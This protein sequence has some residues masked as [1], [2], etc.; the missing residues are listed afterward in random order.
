MAEA[1]EKACLKINTFV[2]E[3]NTNITGLF[4]QYGGI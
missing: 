3:L 4:V 1:A 2:E